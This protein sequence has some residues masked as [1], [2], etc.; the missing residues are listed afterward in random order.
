MDGEGGGGRDD[1]WAKL[2]TVCM[3]FMEVILRNVFV[4]GSA[5]L[6]KKCYWSLCFVSGSLYL[7]MKCT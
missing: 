6:T 7:P 5:C 4:S 2:V 1:A 3:L